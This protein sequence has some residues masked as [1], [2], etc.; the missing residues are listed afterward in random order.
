MAI[1]FVWDRG[2][3]EIMAF[4]TSV[5]ALVPPPPT[6]EGGGGETT[7]FTLLNPMLGVNGWLGEAPVLVVSIWI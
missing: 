4:S 3:W 7:T 5:E 1:P 6:R 2:G